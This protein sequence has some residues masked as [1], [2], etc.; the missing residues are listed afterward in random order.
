MCEQTLSAS[1]GLFEETVNSFIPPTALPPSYS[2]GQMA[3]TVRRVLAAMGA[4]VSAP[5]GPRP[6]CTSTSTMERTSAA[7]TPALRMMEIRL[8]EERESFVPPKPMPCVVDAYIHT[9]TQHIISLK[10]SIEFVLLYYWI[11]IHMLI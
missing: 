2:V 6:V 10:L 3:S 7:S 4:S 11:Q 8:L 1:C 5:E 9:Y